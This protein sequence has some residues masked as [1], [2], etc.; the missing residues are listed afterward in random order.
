MT[1]IVPLSLRVGILST[2]ARTIRSSHT[3]TSHYTKHPPAGSECPPQS[4]R[5]EHSNTRISSGKD[6]AGLVLSVTY[7]Q[8]S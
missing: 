3:M 1:T 8:K 5:H 4:A 2:S 6:E 7:S